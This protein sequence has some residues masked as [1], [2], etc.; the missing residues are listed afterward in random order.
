MNNGNRVCTCLYDS[1]PCRNVVLVSGALSKPSHSVR[2]STLSHSVYLRLSP[3]PDWMAKAK[4]VTIQKI[5]IGIEEHITFNHEGDEPSTKVN[6]IA[7]Q[8]QAVGQKLPEA[9]YNTNLGLIFPAKDTRDSD[10]IIPRGK[11]AFPMYAVTSFT[12]T[13]SLYKI[14]FYLT[15]KVALFI[16]VILRSPLHSKLWVITFSDYVDTF[17]CI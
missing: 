17:R 16:L 7:K 1:V 13:G 15:V 2:A 4:R 14:E 8:V 5:V 10:G 6:K 11:P 12:T 9:G 3:N